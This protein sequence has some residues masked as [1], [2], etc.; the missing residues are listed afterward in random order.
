MAYPLYYVV[1]RARQRQPWMSALIANAGAN[2]RD[3]LV[4]NGCRRRGLPICEARRAVVESR[5]CV[6]T[7]LAGYQRKPQLS[8][9]ATGNA[10]A[11]LQVAAGGLVGGGDLQDA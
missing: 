9:L 8:L 7:N 1:Q 2:R 5:D 6:T 3:T 4:T 11:R 10:A